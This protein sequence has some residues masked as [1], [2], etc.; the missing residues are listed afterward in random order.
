M[1]SCIRKNLKPLYNDFWGIETSKMTTKDTVHYTTLLRKTIIVRNNIKNAMIKNFLNE[2]ETTIAEKEHSVGAAFCTH[3]Q[4]TLPQYDKSYVN[5]Y[6]RVD[7]DKE[8]P[9]LAIHCE[10]LEYQSI[11]YPNNEMWQLP[12]ITDD[13]LCILCKMEREMTLDLSKIRIANNNRVVLL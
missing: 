2:L 1:S 7:R 9:C 12:A 11:V 4:F 13:G 6:K 10:W 8:M 3:S 5:P